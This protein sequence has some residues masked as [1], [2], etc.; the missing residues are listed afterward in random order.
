MQCSKFNGLHFEH[1]QNSAAYQPRSG[2][3][4]LGE[5]NTAVC[6]EVKAGQGGPNIL[7]PPPNLSESVSSVDKQKAQS[8][9]CSAPS[10]SARFKGD[11]ARE[12]P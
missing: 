11:N 10:A 6:Q 12:N 8:L 4:E 2:G 5:A 3:R 9:P 7:A 1:P